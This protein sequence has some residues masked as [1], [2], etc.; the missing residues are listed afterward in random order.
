MQYIYVTITCYLHMQLASHIHTHMHMYC[1]PALQ[2]LIWRESLL[3]RPLL[4][5]ARFWFPVNCLINQWMEHNTKI[6][7][8]SQTSLLHIAVWAAEPCYFPGG[9]NDGKCIFECSKPT[10]L[11]FSAS[12]PSATADTI[13]PNQAPIPRNWGGAH[14]RST[15]HFL[16]NLCAD[17]AMQS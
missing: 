17:M 3:E 1:L 9:R 14:H 15:Y 2:Q 6:K 12:V 4:D 11:H 8:L 10:S 7:K 13:L 16:A 5:Y